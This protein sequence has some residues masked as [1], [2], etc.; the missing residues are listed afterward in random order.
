MKPDIAAIRARAEAA[1]PAPWKPG[2]DSYDP[3]GKEGQ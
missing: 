1:S 3:D 2:L